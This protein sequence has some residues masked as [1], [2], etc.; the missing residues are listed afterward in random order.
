MK[1]SAFIPSKHRFPFDLVNLIRK[2]VEYSFLFEV[3]FVR[4]TWA[5]TLPR[6]ELITRDWNFFSILFYFILRIQI[7]CYRYDWTLSWGSLRLYWKW[8]IQVLPYEQCAQCTLAMTNLK[9]QNCYHACDRYPYSSG[10]IHNEQ[11]ITNLNIHWI[12]C[13]NHNNDIKHDLPQNGTRK[14]KQCVLHTTCYV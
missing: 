11:S 5:V 9:S 6:T 12:E 8:S 3:S 10:W 13:V 4:I 1:H 7:V 2:S 14:N